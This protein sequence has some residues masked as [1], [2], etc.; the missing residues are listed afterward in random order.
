VGGRDGA[1]L[2]NFNT[3][4]GPRTSEE[5]RCAPP[6]ARHV[7]S[8]RVEKQRFI[9]AT[10]HFL[11]APF[12]DYGANDLDPDVQL[13]WEDVRALRLLARAEAIICPICLC[14]PTSPM[15]YKCGHVHCLPCVLRFHASCDSSGTSCRC[16]ICNDHLSIT[17]LRTVCLLAVELVHAGQHTP[18]TLCKLRKTARRAAL[19]SASRALELRPL[20]ANFSELS[21]AASQELLEIERDA[22]QKEL[23]K[24]RAE[25]QA[26]AAVAAASAQCEYSDGGGTP[27]ATAEVIEHCSADAIGQ[28]SVSASM[29]PARNAWGGRPMAPSASAAAMP[30]ATS[31]VDGVTAAAQQE[32][33]A[34][35]EAALELIA[36]RRRVWEL[37]D[38][39]TRASS[40]SPRPPL[41]GASDGDASGDE[42]KHSWYLQAA[43]GQ[44]CFADPFS[45]R[46]LLAHYGGW[47]H[48]PSQLTV[49]LFELQPSRQSESTRKRFKALAH[50]PLGCTFYLAEL[51]L[52]LFLSDELKQQF[53]SEL[54]RRADRRLRTKEEELRQK[55][56]EERRESERRKHGKSALAEELE[57][58]SLSAREAARRR[59]Q[60]QYAAPE[61]HLAPEWQLQ[62]EQQQQQ[63]QQQETPSFASIAQFGFGAS[64]PSLQLA[65][66][67]PP[68]ASSR[69]TLSPPCASPTLLPSPMLSAPWRP[70]G[71]LSASPPMALP[72]SCSAS[73]PAPAAGTSLLQGAPPTVFG[74]ALKTGTAESAD[75]PAEHGAMPQS[76]A[77]AWASASCVA[78]PD[79]Q[80]SAASMSKSGRRREKQLLLSNSGGRRA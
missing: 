71:S 22:L 12:K 80:A 32:E 3:H 58:M 77:V 48:V 2:L 38:E 50:L 19:P 68:L 54:K 8:R 55:D 44:L 39:K 10:F 69:S 30:R 7:A 37:A 63:Q 61:I 73:A 18:L 26:M 76:L 65:S 53:A 31:D 23:V 56:E 21:P 47:A 25:A 64:G 17:D 24:V 70:C 43:D 9:Q 62:W 35:L 33:E 5:P 46:L 1:Y 16:P 20:A 57:T 34:A 78:D 51:D 11:M 72:P 75:A 52:G 42:A 45:V 28:Q 14:E 49:P 6:R 41:D 15:T 4:R 27:A 13:D 36:Q 40:G 67:S 74:F 66:S 59:Q 29:A 79:M 60:S